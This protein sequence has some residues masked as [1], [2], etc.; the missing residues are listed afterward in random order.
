MRWIGVFASCLLGAWTYTAK[1][2]ATVDGPQQALVPDANVSYSIWTVSGREVMLR[3]LLP[4]S[5]SES[6]VGRLPSAVVT[7]SLGDYLLEHTAVASSDQDCPAEDQG[8]DIGRV[9]PLSV[10]S[11]LYGFEIFFRCPTGRGL[12]LTDSALF[13]RQPGHVNFARIELRGRFHE[14]IFTSV[15]RRLSLPDAGVPAV[16]GEAAY[17][18]LGAHHV[19]QRPD[20]VCFLLGAALLFAEGSTLGGLALGLGAGYLFSGALAITDWIVP[21]DDMP[22]AS[23]GLL[24]A[25]LAG[26]YVVR[27]LRERS[28]AIGV[29]LAVALLPACAAVILRRSDAALLLVGGALFCGSALAV[30]VGSS[31]RLP[32][33]ALVAFLLAMVDGFTLPRVLLPLELPA[34]A[35]LPM[36]AGFDTGA[37]AAE[38][39]LICATVAARRVLGNRFGKNGGV[40][41]ATLMRDVVAAA[42][43]GLGVFWLISRSLSG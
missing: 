36:L 16:S 26:L 39:V 31:G 13:D 28:R 37:L 12:A 8:Y 23:V 19:L 32:L 14:E 33:L 1:A 11:G 7:R 38:L 42:L 24:L 15:R 29:S 5:E 40:A 9:D 6:L 3:F 17:A 41:A 43:G 10:G 2:T 27:E 25:L 35:R 4:V 20:L 30:R 21:R 34:S 22:G 18:R